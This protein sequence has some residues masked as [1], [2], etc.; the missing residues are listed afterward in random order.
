MVL[1]SWWGSTHFFR[2]FADRL[3]DVGFTVMVPDITFGESFDDAEAAQLHLAEADPNRLVRLTLDSLVLLQERTG[4]APVSIVGFSMGASLGLWASVRMGEAVNAVAAFYGTQVIDFEGAS[5]R[6]QLHL[7]E[8][9]HLVDPDDAT[10]MEA[11][12]GL[13]GLE[14]ESHL[15]RNVGHWFMEDDQPG[16]DPQ[17]AHLAWDRLIGFLTG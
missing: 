1:P 13:A 7:V 4:G 10:F 12:M 15:Y 8:G 2:R 5:A 17:A 6:Y 14:V 3:A 16:H 9:D 11:T